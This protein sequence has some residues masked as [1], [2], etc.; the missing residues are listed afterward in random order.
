MFSTVLNHI[1]D[2]HEPAGFLQMKEIS[3]IYSASGLC[4]WT[5][6]FLHQRLLQLQAYCGHQQNIR[7]VVQFVHRINLSITSLHFT[8]L[9]FT[10]LHFTSLHYAPSF[11]SNTIRATLQLTDPCVP[12]KQCRHNNPQ[13][14]RNNSFV[15]HSSRRFGHHMLSSGK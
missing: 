13:C 12:Y 8:S 10:S 15:P 2:V 11:S 3:H 4:P 5:A 14:A 6:Q 7:Y 1:T 9:H